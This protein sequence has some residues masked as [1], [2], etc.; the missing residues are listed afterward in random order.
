[1]GN[2]PVTLDFS[3]AQPIAPIA[4]PSTS[5]AVTLDFSKAEPIAGSPPPKQSYW[6]QVSQGLVQGM[7][8]ESDPQARI[9]AGKVALITG[10]TMATAGA[11]SGALAPS[12]VGT[13]TVGTGILDAAGEEITREVAKYGPS[14]TRAVLSSP[15]VQSILKHAAI[16]AGTGMG[17]GGTIAILKKLG[18]W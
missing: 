8:D 4:S 9:A 13:E 12:V 6:E 16:S 3:K 14:A 11:V 7:K 18:V 1:V 17:L 5:S 2:G 15:V 10:A